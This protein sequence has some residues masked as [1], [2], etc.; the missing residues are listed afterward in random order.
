MNKIRAAIP[1]VVATLLLAF[2][3]YQLPACTT[4]GDL[5]DLSGSDEDTTSDNFDVDTESDT[6][7]DAPS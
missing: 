1:Y 2:A 3:A 4:G 7:M 5:D 6:G